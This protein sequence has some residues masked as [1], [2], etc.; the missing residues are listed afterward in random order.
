MPRKPPASMT[1][2]KPPWPKPERVTPATPARPD[3]LP[4][5]ANKGGR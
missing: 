1:T 2:P 4:S 5:G 3:K